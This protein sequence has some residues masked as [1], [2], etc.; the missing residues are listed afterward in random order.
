MARYKIKVVNKLNVNIGLILILPISL[1]IPSFLLFLKVNWII[2]I[3]SAILIAFFLFNLLEKK[4]SY[5]LN[6]IL[7]KDSISFRKDKNE[8]MLF[9]CK[10]DEIKSF[11][12]KYINNNFPSFKII[13]HSNNKFKFNCKNKGDNDYHK[14][15][16]NFEKAFDS[17]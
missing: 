14:F 17:V 10:L 11:K 13:T 1:L 7:S 3:V 15:I 8:E 2:Y 16:K 4:S 12:I 9:E 6:I 5:L